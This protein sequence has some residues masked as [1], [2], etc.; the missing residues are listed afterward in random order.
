YREYKGQGDDHHGGRV[1]ITT[2]DN[3]HQAEGDHDA[4]GCVDMYGDKLRKLRDDAGDNQQPRE[5][6]AAD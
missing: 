1:Q 3:V 4:G 2:H 5:N 6:Q